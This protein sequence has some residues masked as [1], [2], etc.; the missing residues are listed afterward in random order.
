M[1]LN[2]DSIE[3]AVK[4][5]AT[6]GDTDVFPYPFENHIF[7]DKPESIVSLIENMDRDFEVW[8]FNYPP[9]Y[10]KSLSTSGYVGFRSPSQIDPFWNA[11]FLALTIS[12]ADDI[13][14]SRIPTASNTVFS[15]RVSMDHVSGALFDPYI[16]WHQFQN[17][18]LNRAKASGFVLTCDISDFYSRVYH[19]RLE[20]SLADA[21]TDIPTIQRII[22][23]L[24]KF[25]DGKSYGI[26]IGGPAS[27]I[28][29]ESLLNRVDKL[30]RL[31]GIPFCRFV[32]DYHLFAQSKEQAYSY[33]VTLSKLLVD[34]EGLS[35]QKTKTRIASKDEFMA[36]SPIGDGNE[37]ESVAEKEAADFQ[38][39]RI[40]YDPYAPT[41]NEDYL[42]LCEEINKFD[43]VAMLGRQLLK[44][45]VDESLTRQLV[46]AIKFLSPSS[47]DGAIVSLTKNI[48]TLYPIFPTI[49]M[50]FIQVIGD[51]SVSTRTIVFE[52][53]RSLI[54]SQSYIVSVS[55]NLAYAIRVLGYDAS[56]ETATL[57][58]ELYKSNHDDMIRRDIICA[59]M[60]TANRPWISNLKK[61]YNSSAPWEKRAFVVASYLLGDEGRHWRRAISN[62]LS[63]MD[64]L[65]NEWAADR[66]QANK[67]EGPL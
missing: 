54:R 44:P 55:A 4:N 23:L 34:N 13:E 18:S 41:A 63:P 53:L 24:A 45:R 60:R 26:P 11:Y 39:L 22:K 30:L 10:V 5:I 57:M 16:G 12:L 1:A 40:R 37:V 50:L 62:Q 14:A 42:A 15:Y 66:K 64:K 61:N 49:A 51:M 65:V 36:V 35:L 19:H 33:L 17:E 56:L 47:R 28:L 7:H 67:L 58:A 29:A 31:E 25:S 46:K 27:R 8:L 9:T 32:D 48:S 20:N 21:S 38:R 3:L 6:Y 2:K 43:I 59:M 52:T